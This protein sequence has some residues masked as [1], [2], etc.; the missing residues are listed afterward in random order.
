MG[1]Q[2]QPQ[3]LWSIPRPERADLEPGPC[4]PHAHLD[5]T[6]ARRRLA[7]LACPRSE[8]SA[9][10]SCLPALPPL[11]LSAFLSSRSHSCWV[12]GHR[13]LQKVTAWPPQLSPFLTRA[14]LPPVARAHI[15]CTQRSCYWSHYWSLR[16]VGGRSG[17][18][19]CHSQ[20]A[21]PF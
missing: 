4:L 18:T 12:Q 15:F 14:P 5:L 13:C 3:W 2:R 1:S 19:L 20:S 8:G 6:V 17:V 11:S 21:V 9:T 7:A 10:F 16:D